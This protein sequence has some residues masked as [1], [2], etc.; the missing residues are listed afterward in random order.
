MK[1]PFFL[2]TSA[3]V[4]ALFAACGTE[5]PDSPLSWGTTSFERSSKLDSTNISAVDE[6]RSHHTGENCVQCHQ[7]YGPGR[8]RFTVAGSIA[9]P[10]GRWLPNPVLEL[11]NA[12]PDKGGE[13]VFRL[14]GDAKGNVFTTEPLPFPEQPLFPRVLDFDGTLTHS[15]PFPVTDGACNHCHTG[16]FR[17]TLH[18]HSEHETDEHAEHADSEHAD[19]DDTDGN[20]IDSGDADGEHA[21]DENVDTHEPT[22]EHVDAT[23]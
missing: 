10:D 1:S 22:A 11:L 2:W 15:M 3:A 12:P 13:V 20:G 5:A 19:G 18:E 21:T 17:I 9:G 4:G 6:R 7:A 23:D 16:G 14:Q 8:G